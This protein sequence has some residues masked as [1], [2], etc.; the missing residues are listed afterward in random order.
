MFIRPFTTRV[1]RHPP[2]KKRF[3]GFIA[4]HRR[5]IKGPERGRENFPKPW[6][7]SAP[8]GPGGDNR[9]SDVSKV[10]NL[11]AVAG[12]LDPTATGCYAGDRE[13]P[14][15]EAVMA[16]QRSAGLEA[17]G[18]LVPG[19]PTID[20]LSCPSAEYPGFT[21]TARELPAALARLP[22]GIASGNVRAIGK[23]LRT[24]YP[25][26]LPDEMAAVWSGTIE[27]K[28]AVIDLVDRLRLRSRS[29]ADALRQRLAPLLPARDRG[30]LYVTAGLRRLAAIHAATVD[31]EPDS[32]PREQA[33]ARN[34][35]RIRRMKAQ[36]QKV[37]DALDWWGARVRRASGKHGAA[38][39]LGV[40][41]EVFDLQKKQ[42]SILKR[43]DALSDENR[44]LVEEATQ[45]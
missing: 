18:Y 26:R 31:A 29:T 2:P 8:V 14:L 15:V 43:I 41:R 10:K 32:H 17:D 11:V 6:R 37:E 45:P 44:E 7:L 30:L 36:L 35:R 5:P 28:A 39:R 20:A 19:G 13:A 21:V 42:E 23:L 16:F 3:A 27:D 22:S 4:T 40:A 33:L 38:D 9:L 25:G 24:G 34:I 1:R 12:R